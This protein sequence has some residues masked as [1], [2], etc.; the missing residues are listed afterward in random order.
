MRLIAGVLV[1]VVYLEVF[2]VLGGHKFMAVGSYKATKPSRSLFFALCSKFLRF[3]SFLW[4]SGF[5]LSAAYLEVRQRTW[6]VPTAYLEDIRSIFQ[7]VPETFLS[8]LC[9]MLHE[10][11]R[12][13]PTDI[14]NQF[15]RML[16]AGVLDIC[17]S[18]PGDDREGTWGTCNEVSGRPPWRVTSDLKSRKILR[19]QREWVP[20]NIKS[21]RGRGPFFFF[22]WT[23]HLQ[24]DRVPFFCS[25]EGQIPAT[26]NRCDF[27]GWRVWSA[28]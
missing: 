9:S 21:K 11:P 28:L 18:F 23:V 16:P 6:R 19:R 26:R 7:G 10:S 3:S 4:Y 15:S 20:G 27:L 1:F 5:R 24:K 2:Y 8:G 22:W 12:Y 14:R 17:S 13:V 25:T